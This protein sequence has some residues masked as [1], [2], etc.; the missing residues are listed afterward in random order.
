[1]NR[2]NC[3]AII[4]IVAVTVFLYNLIFSPKN[5]NGFLDEMKKREIKSIIIKKYINYDNHN[6]PFLIYDNKDSIV[7]YRDWWDKVSV[8]DSI[9]KPKGCLEIVIK[10]SVK[11][12]KF[13]YEAK[14]GLD[15]Q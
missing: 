7:I 14:F 15:G 3:L 10:N 13:D 2:N 1:M 5:R 9:L 11:D 6:I 8:G 12:E 4:L